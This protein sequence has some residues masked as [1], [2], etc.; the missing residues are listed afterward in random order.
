MCTFSAG[1]FSFQHQLF[2]IDS[3]I[4]NKSCFFCV[5]HIVGGEKKKKKPTPCNYK[6][7]PVMYLWE[8][9]AAIC[10]NVKE[11]KTPLCSFLEQTLLTWNSSASYRTGSAPCQQ[12]LRFR[13]VCLI[14]WNYFYG[15]NTKIDWNSKIQ[16]WTCCIWIPH[17]F[18]LNTATACCSARAHPTIRRRVLSAGGRPSSPSART[19]KKRDP[20]VWNCRPHARSTTS[21]GRQSFVS[22]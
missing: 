19:K 4:K 20:T 9:R 11:K 3:V 1:D 18:P 13:C 12:P 14:F 17:R 6:P 5:C 8:K 21:A 15:V 10:V 16:D 7:A 22:T 2:D